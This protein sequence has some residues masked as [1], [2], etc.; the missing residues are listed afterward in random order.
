MTLRT[1]RPHV[2]SYSEEKDRHVILFVDQRSCMFF[3]SVEVM[4]S[5]AGPPQVEKHHPD[6][7]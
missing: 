6:L 2:R 5:D 1:G 3:S 4:K 7:S